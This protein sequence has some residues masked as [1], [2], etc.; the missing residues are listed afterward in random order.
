MSSQP[1]NPLHGITLKVLLQELVDRH[2][3][4][5]L[6]Q[7]TG[8]KCFLYNPTFNS[9]LKTLRK[10]PWAREEVEALYLR[11]VKARQKPSP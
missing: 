4:D 3:F 1:N 2:G 5:A 9:I 8:L 11:D 10:H 7:A 6:G